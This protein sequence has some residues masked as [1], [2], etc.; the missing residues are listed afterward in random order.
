MGSM[1]F[2]DFLAF[3]HQFW[4]GLH[5]F[6]GRIAFDLNICAMAGGIRELNKT[7]META[8]QRCRMINGAGD[9]DRTR[10]I[11]LGKLAFYR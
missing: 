9:G 11:Q 1:A 10:G 4:D 2:I 3:G 7:E 6:I 8:V 5:Q